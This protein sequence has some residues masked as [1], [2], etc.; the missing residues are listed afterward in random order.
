MHD[1]RPTQFGTVLRMDG[2]IDHAATARLAE[3][4]DLDDIH[5][6]VTDW[7]GFEPKTEA[8]RKDLYRRYVRMLADQCAAE[9]KARRKAR[10]EWRRSRYR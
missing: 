4:K 9:A 7:A 3:Q 2:R 5:R 10:E 1:V 6:R 8:D